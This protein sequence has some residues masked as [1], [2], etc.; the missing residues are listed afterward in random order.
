MLPAQAVIK[1]RAVT[2][3]FALSRWKRTGRLVV[4]ERPPNV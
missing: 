1:S 4:V 2:R 3:N